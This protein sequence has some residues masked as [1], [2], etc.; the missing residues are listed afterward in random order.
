VAK[1]C[2]IFQTWIRAA[3]TILFLATVL[4]F[5]T[6]GDAQT[7]E[8]YVFGG[9]GAT[10]CCRGAVAPSLQLGGGVE[11]FMT[12]HVAIGVEGGI[13]ASPDVEL[14]AL[15]VSANG[16]Y[17]FRRASRVGELEPFVTGGYTLLLENLQGVNVGTG[18]QYWMTRQSALRVEFR[19]HVWPREY[20]TIHSWALR[21]GITLR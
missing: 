21:V 19:D 14:A 3:R 9:G 2:V 15:F 1:E 12:P 17:F 20:V 16:L 10:L 5:G 18:F 13:L 4:L 7:T 11:R 6:R 8:G